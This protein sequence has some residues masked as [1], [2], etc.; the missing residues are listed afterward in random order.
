MCHAIYTCVHVLGLSL[1]VAA[2]YVS[3]YDEVLEKVGKFRFLA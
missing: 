1:G 2:A 3:T